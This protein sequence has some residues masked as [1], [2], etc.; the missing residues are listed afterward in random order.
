MKIKIIN[1]VSVKEQ[2]NPASKKLKYEVCLFHTK[3]EDEIP[4]VMAKFKFFGDAYGYADRL[5][6]GNCYYEAV[7]IR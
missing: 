1:F 2:N 4:E 3:S 5:A 6:S 7:L